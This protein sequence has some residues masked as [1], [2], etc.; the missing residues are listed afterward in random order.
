SSTRPFIPRPKSAPDINS[1]PPPS[2]SYLPPSTESMNSSRSA[3]SPI[4]AFQKKL[5]DYIRKMKNTNLTTHNLEKFNK[6]LVARYSTPSPYYKGL[7]DF[8]LVI[9]REKY[10]GSSHGRES[11]ATSFVSSGSKSSFVLKV[12]EWGSYF[13]G[14]RKLDKTSSSGTSLMKSSHD[15]RAAKIRETGTMITKIR[16]TTTKNDQESYSDWK[17]VTFN[18][19][20]SKYDTIA[21][22]NKC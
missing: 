18:S 21:S 5:D 10:S 4:T 16:T 3:G 22:S 1:P 13:T 14:A 9:N 7:T 20:N 8:S 15:I 17:R 11:N 6:S 2:N 12:Q 19:I